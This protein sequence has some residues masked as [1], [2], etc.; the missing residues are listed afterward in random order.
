MVAPEGEISTLQVVLRR[1]MNALTELSF[2]RSSNNSARQITIK[3]VETRAGIEGDKLPD[4]DMQGQGSS[5]SDQW[6]HYVV[7]YVR[8][9]TDDVDEFKMDIHR[10]IGGQVSVFC[11]CSGKCNPLIISGRRKEDQRVCMNCGCQRP[12]KY[13]CCRVGCAT[14]ICQSCFDT[15]A[16]AGRDRVYL[17]PPPTEEIHS[18]YSDMSDD[19]FL[20]DDEGSQASESVS[21]DGSVYEL[22]SMDGLGSDSDHESDDEIPDEDSL[23]RHETGTRELEAGLGLRL[24]S[25]QDSLSDG[26]C[27]LEYDSPEEYWSESDD[28]DNRPEGSSQLD[29]RHDDLHDGEDVLDGNQSEQRSGDDDPEEHRPL[30]QQEETR[31]SRI[32]R[33]AGMEPFQNVDDAMENFHTFTLVNPA[34][35]DLEDIVDGDSDPGEDDVRVPFTDAGEKSL[36]ILR[37]DDANVS[38]SRR[39][40]GPLFVILNLFGSLNTRRNKKIKGTQAQQSFVQRMVSRPRGRSVSLTYLAGSL[41]PGHFY[42]SAPNDSMAICGVLPVSTYRKGINPD[43]FASHLQTARNLITLACSTTQNDHHLHYFL[44]SVLA[45]QVSSGV[46]SE[47]IK[48]SGFR[49][50]HASPSGISVRDA[51]ESTL[52][53]S[54]DSRQ[55]VMDLAATA[56]VHPMDFFIT[57]T[58]NQKMHPG[59]SHLH[60]W[61]S[62]MEWT[63]QVL[64]YDCLSHSHKEEAKKS[65]DMAY[66]CL[67]NRCWLEV[68]KELIE[69]IT[70]RCEE[71][72]G[73]DATHVF[74]RDEHQE[75]TGAL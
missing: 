52:T 15:H 41:L 24:D 40:Q 11:P 60:D 55:C 2:K 46:H 23:P 64:D 26:L 34:D 56:V 10:S 48:R 17:E 47:Q 16:N 4:L 68:R 51:D 71:M 28:D 29:P 65:F 57:L 22:A 21:E 69:F 35:E 18:S 63:E 3:H 67:V 59:V 73:K 50:C 25:D 58:L 33:S 13:T 61:L 54:A 70:Y 45:N 49:V 72:F 14:R 6:F 32:L 66:C 5:R 30:V 53:E 37:R 7:V 38:A 39:A 74:F 12:E 36:K 8:V 19:G 31:S 44:Y 62:S 75:T 9:G 20:G 42:Q 27:G 1:R 43:G